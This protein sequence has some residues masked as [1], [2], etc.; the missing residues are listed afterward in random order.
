MG[1]PVQHTRQVEVSGSRVDG[2]DELDL[3]PHATVGPRDCRARHW[4]A[5]CD[6]PGCLVE[7][8]GCLVRKGAPLRGQGCLQGFYPGVLGWCGAARCR[9]GGGSRGTFLAFCAG[10]RS[11]RWRLDGRGG[12]GRRRAGGGSAVQCSP[13][14]S[15]CSSAGTASAKG[16]RAGPRPFPLACRCDRFPCSLACGP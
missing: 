13:C 4:S 1:H 8:R 3:H 12:R 16:F 7:A 11:S 9:F 6:G 2:A 15:T 14:R 5:R 10:T